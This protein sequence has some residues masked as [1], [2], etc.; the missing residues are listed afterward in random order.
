MQAVKSEDSDSV[1]VYEDEESKPSRL[2]RKKHAMN[3]YNAETSK[4]L[5]LNCAHSFG[6]FLIQEA[7][8]R[9]ET[10]LEDLDWRVKTAKI[11]AE[12]CVMR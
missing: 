8:E 10:L 3:V 2:K 11:I 9:R 7:L 6:N 12:N 5:S 4:T 1:S